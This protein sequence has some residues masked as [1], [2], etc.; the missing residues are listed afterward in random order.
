[1][2]HMMHIII[3]YAP[4]CICM[5]TKQSLWQTFLDACL[6]SLFEKMCSNTVCNVCYFPLQVHINV[7][8]QDLQSIT[9]PNINMPPIDH[10]V[11]GKGISGVVLIPS[12]HGKKLPM[13]SEADFVKLAE[14][15]TL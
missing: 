10:E 13:Y 3:M 15:G 6:Q 2:N 12:A 7:L 14:A 4:V 9:N 1:M 5:H 8:V 11:A